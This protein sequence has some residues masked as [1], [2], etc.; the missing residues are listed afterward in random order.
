MGHNVDQY[1]SLVN[2][3]IGPLVG[4]TYHHHNEILA[5]EHASIVDGWLQELL[6]LINPL[7]EI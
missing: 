5:K 4:P 6:I 2:V 3:E 7:L 1:F